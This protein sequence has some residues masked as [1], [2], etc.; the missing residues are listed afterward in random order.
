MEPRQ[1]VFAHL[2]NFIPWYDFDA[3]IRRY[4]NDH[5]PRGFT[6][7]D[8]FICMAFAQCA[9]RESL[10]DIELCLRTVE[11]KLGLAGFRRMVS[12]NSLADAN[13]AHDGRIFADFAQALISRARKLYLDECIFVE[14][15]QAVCAFDGVTV[16][17]CLG[18]FPLARFRRSKGG[19]KLHMLLDLAGSIF[20]FV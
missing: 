18:V 8:Q 4:S 10:R 12:R 9:F 7:P 13:C 6:G 11:P 14:L 17:L 3:C 20:C 1:L 15:D 5:Y 16:D 2:V 19:V